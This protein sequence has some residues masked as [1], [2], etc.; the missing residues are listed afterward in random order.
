MRAQNDMDFDVRIRSVQ[1]PRVKGFKWDFYFQK[2]K[3]RYVA[4]V[5][6]TNVRVEYVAIELFP[7]I[8]FNE[9]TGT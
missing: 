1:P 5:E 4:P 2:Q 9:P 7:S 8:G 3:Q 6:K